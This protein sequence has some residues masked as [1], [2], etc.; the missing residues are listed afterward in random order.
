MTTECA[1][2]NYQLTEGVLSYKYQLR[3]QL[4]S[5]QKL[6]HPPHGCS[7]IREIKLHHV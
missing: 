5:C 6:I 4:I 7:V 2:E 3:P 1:A